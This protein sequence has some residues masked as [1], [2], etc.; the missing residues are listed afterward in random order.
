MTYTPASLDNSFRDFVAKDVRGNL[1]PEESA[2][3]RHPDNLDR[4]RNAL[5]AIKREVEIQLANRNARWWKKQAELIDQGT[6]GRDEWIRFRA[7]EVDWRV[8]AIRFLVTVE[9]HL[10][11]NAEIYKQYQKE[12]PQLQATVTAREIP[13]G[14]DPWAEVERLKTAIAQHREGIDEAAA[15]ESDVVLWEAIE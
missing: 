1:S 9:E 8:R 13:E 12:E 15:S 7:T 4:W 10:S 5:I 14:D 6:A 3:L 2:S 11:A